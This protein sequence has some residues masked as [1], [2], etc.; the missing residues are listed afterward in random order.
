MGPDWHEAMVNS[1]NDIF[2]MFYEE[3]VSYF[4]SFDNLETIRRINDP[5]PAS[6]LV[7]NKKSVTCCVGKSSK[8]S[9]T[10]VT[11]TTKT[12]LIAERFLNL[13]SRK[14]LDLKL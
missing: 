13:N 10:I 5:S 1:N 8:G 11:R 2:A 7:D 4:E 3:L 9:N 6:L 12:R 14:M